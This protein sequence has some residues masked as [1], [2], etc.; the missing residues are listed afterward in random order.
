MCVCPMSDVRM[1]VYWPV[2]SLL[3]QKI[4]KTILLCIPNVVDSHSSFCLICSLYCLDIYK[5]MGPSNSL[6]SDAKHAFCRSKQ[7]ENRK[8]SVFEQWRLRQRHYQPMCVYKQ[9]SMIWSNECGHMSYRFY[10]RRIF[11]T[12][13]FTVCSVHNIGFLDPIQQTF[14][15]L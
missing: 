1:S 14:Y 13:I 15:Y 4:T 6:I 11:Y 2:C 7:M 5:S 9:T 3:N 12:P 8:I 10:W